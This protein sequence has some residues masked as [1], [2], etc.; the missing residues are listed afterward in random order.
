MSSSSSSRDSLTFLVPSQATSSLSYLINREAAR[1]IC[2]LWEKQRQ[3]KT[4]NSVVHFHCMF[5]VR[6]IVLLHLFHQLGSC[7][8]PFSVC[9]VLKTTQTWCLPSSGIVDLY[10]NAT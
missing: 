8:R 1:A 3:L 4:E 9:V 5:T 7:D 10:C 2:S 6:Y